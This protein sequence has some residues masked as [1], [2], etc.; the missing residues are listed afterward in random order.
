MAI[1]N[2]LATAY[3][4]ANQDVGGF[5]LVPKIFTSNAELDEY[6]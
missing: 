3:K 1:F 5:E 2:D 6:V 4:T